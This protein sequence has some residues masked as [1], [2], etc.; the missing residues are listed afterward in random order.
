MNKLLEAA[1]NARDYLKQ[2]ESL[3]GEVTKLVCELNKGIEEGEI[4]RLR[5]INHLHN[6]VELN[7]LALQITR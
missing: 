7:Q 6:Q 1:R 2:R 4:A 3:T 5:I